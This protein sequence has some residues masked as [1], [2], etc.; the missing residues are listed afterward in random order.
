MLNNK[1]NRELAEEYARVTTEVGLLMH[2][3]DDP[4]YESEQEKMKAELEG[5][6]K[7]Q[8]EFFEIIHN[9]LKHENEEYGTDY[10]LDGI[11]T[12]YIVTPFMKANGYRDGG[13]WWVKDDGK[14]GV[15]IMY[16]PREN[17]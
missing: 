15:V 4:D 11:G 6:R 8:N 13:G 14:T 9:I 5:W 2:Y 7:K 10:I 3:I 17:R 12:H 16:K 1:K